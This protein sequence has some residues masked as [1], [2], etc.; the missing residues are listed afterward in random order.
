M[1]RSLEKRLRAALGVAVFVAS[2][3]GD[4]RRTPAQTV[5]RSGVD[6]VFVTAT[7]VDRDG[8]FVAGLS[9]DDFV[10]SEEGRPQ[11]IVS[12]TANRV[13][14]SLGIA[15]DVSGSMTPP[16]IEAARAAIRRLVNDLLGVDDELF[17][18]V[19]ERRTTMLR[20]WTTDRELF[21]RAL[22]GARVGGTTALY[23][24][25]R[26]LLPVAESGRHDKKA[27]LVVSDGDDRASRISQ[28]DLQ[29]SVRASNVLV[30]ALGV[31]GGE[32]INA[33]NLRR[34][35]DDTGGRTEVINGFKNL[36][37]ATARLADELNRQY[38]LAYLMPGTRDGRW[39]PIK[40]EVRRRGV[41]VRARA[42]YVR[43]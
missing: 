7:V 34:F 30:Y 23:D 43:Q 6:L 17:F 25:V 42:G 26:R 2:L 41:V 19:F 20:E 21:G 37:A 4:V 24:A 31:D 5:Y 35:T 15:L 18:A 36:D 11:T 3:T 1:G 27:L 38:Q 32:G 9:A 16:Q 8:R 28:R 12:F 39:H 13:P 10:V 40:V 22:D 14:V 33:R 29:R